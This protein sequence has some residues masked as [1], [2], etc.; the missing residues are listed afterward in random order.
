MDG[1]RDEEDKREKGEQYKM[2]RKEVKLA[3]T[4]AKKVVLE[5]LY[6][7]LEGKGEDKKLFKLAKARSLDQVKWIKDEEGNVFVEEALNRPRWHTY[8]HKFLNEDRDRDILLGDLRVLGD[9]VGL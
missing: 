1:S 8:F 5:H 4:E 6:A 3:L 2:A 9:K 7:E